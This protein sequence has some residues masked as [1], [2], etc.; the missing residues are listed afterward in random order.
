MLI[1]QISDPHI[2]GREALAYGRIDTGAMLLRAVET[3]NRLRPQADLVIVSGDL[4]QSGHP[5]EYAELRSILTHLKAPFALAAGNHDDRNHLR[6]AF[7]GELPAPTPGPFVQY[8]RILGQMQ[9]VVLDTVTPGSGD[10]SFCEERARWLDRILGA[11]TRPSLLVT[12]HPPFAT[13]IGWMDPATLNWT[14]H[15]ADAILG[16]PGQVIGIVSGH[17][18]RAIHTRAF[19]VPASSCPST[20]HQVAL[21][22][23]EENALFSEEA[24]GFQLHRWEGGQLTT[25]T[26]S[27]D[28]FLAHFDPREA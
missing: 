16:H 21:D 25:Y 1:A 2:V 6:A 8:V 18:H 3:L 13:G 5:A 9:V 12:H 4:V 27:F 19:G 20:A 26:A 11:S 28:R 15:L 14:G 17:I 7:E 24:P 23:L 22:F 10:A